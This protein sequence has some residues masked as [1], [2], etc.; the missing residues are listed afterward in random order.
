MV[1]QHCMLT[2][3]NLFAYIMNETQFYHSHRRSAIQKKKHVKAAQV[4]TCY[5]NDLFL[6]R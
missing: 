1:Y 4:Q 6:T 5:N 3:V 2:D